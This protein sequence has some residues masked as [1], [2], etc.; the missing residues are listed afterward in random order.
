[1][2]EPIEERIIFYTLNA[3]G[4]FGE[5]IK[6]L[7][8]LPVVTAVIGTTDAV[9]ALSRG[10]VGV[11][12]FFGVLSTASIAYSGRSIYRNSKIISEEYK[13]YDS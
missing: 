3:L 12:I 6:R 5:N 11:G 13:L 2:R 9:E 4:A 8:L 7:E 10:D 1:M